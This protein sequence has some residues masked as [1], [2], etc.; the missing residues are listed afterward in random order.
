MKIWKIKKKKI[1][2]NKEK[3]KTLKKWGN[4]NQVFEV[5]S[6]FKDEEKWVELCLVKSSKFFLSQHLLAFELKLCANANC[7]TGQII[8]KNPSLK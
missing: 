8:V 7:A 1:C 2:K 4:Q 5:L 6:Q 3:K